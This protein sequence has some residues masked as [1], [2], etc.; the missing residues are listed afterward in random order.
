MSGRQRPFSRQGPTKTRESV[1]NVLQT[2]KRGPTYSSGLIVSATERQ[3]AEWK[4]GWGHE[5]V[6]FWPLMRISATAVDF[7]AGRKSTAAN[8]IFGQP[9]GVT[10]S[11]RG[12]NPR[13]QHEVQGEQL[14]A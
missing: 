12:E 13:L 2:C 4:N 10:L 7:S 11:H 6:S 5:S 14:L 1:T 8:F 3:S 9:V